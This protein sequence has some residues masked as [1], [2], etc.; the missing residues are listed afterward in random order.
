MPCLRQQEA[1]THCHAHVCHVFAAV[2][3]ANCRRTRYGRVKPCGSKWRLVSA[4]VTSAESGGGRLAQGGLQLRAAGPAGAPAAAL[5]ETR[6]PRLYGQWP[7]ERLPR[8]ACPGAA[9]LAVGGQLLSISTAW[10]AVPGAARVL[11]LAIHC[12][13]AGKTIMP[14]HA[15]C[16]RPALFAREHGTMCAEYNTHWS[17]V[18]AAPSSSVMR[19]WCLT[20]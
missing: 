15:A 19:V 1:G 10:R 2:P 6:H 16:C 7:C 12:K 11:A 4:P 20:E 14:R 3:A 8:V 9:P 17:R 13:C 18:C 5:A